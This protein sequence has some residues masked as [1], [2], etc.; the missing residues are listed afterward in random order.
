[1]YSKLMKPISNKHFMGLA[2]QR[3]VF[4]LTFGLLIAILTSYIY[5]ARI[6]VFSAKAHKYER[7]FRSFFSLVSF[8]PKPGSN[9]IT[10]IFLISNGVDCLV[11]I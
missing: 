1:M 10:R 3:K 4:Y 5:Q 6:V 7:K 9:G 11:Q 8:L 2:L